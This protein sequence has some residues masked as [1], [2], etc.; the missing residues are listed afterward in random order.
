MLCFLSWSVKVKGMYRFDES[1]K[2]WMTGSFARNFL[3]M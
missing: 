3:A 1:Q 2:W